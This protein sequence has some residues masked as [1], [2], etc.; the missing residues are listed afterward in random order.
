MLYKYS[1]FLQG[2]FEPPRASLLEIQTNS[3]TMLAQT[4]FEFD[5]ICN[6]TCY[7]MGQ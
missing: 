6:L 4:V 1:R 2:T 3:R 7:F 5:P